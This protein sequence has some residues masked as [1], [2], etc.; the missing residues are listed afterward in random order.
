MKE[1]KIWDL[2]ELPSNQKPITE[3]WVLVKKSDGCMKAQS[4]TKGFTQVFGMDFEETFLPV[5]R[6]ETV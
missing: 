5:A 2:I 3:K 4:V 1:R 6:F